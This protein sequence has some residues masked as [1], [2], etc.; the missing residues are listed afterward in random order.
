MVPLRTKSGRNPSTRFS[1]VIQLATVPDND[2]AFRRRLSPLKRGTRVLYSPRQNGV[3]LD[4]GIN[5]SFLGL[6][7]PQ[8]VTKMVFKLTNY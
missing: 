4:P 3:A 6:I 8:D 7:S 2:G 5:P 1:P